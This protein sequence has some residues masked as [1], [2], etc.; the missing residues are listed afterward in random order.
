MSDEVEY[1]VARSSKRGRPLSEVM[2][3]NIALGGNLTLPRDEAIKLLQMAESVEQSGDVVQ[4]FQ[5]R[6]LVSEQR[7]DALMFRMI[8][9]LTIFMLSL[10]LLGWML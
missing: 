1:L 9:D 2:R 6:M 8:R 10:T 4:T 3:V 5:A 7:R